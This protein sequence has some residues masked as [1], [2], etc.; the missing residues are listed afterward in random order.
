M[1]MDLKYDYTMQNLGHK[2]AQIKMSRVQTALSRKQIQN[3]L[4]EIEQKINEENH[5]D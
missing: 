3:K 4:L 5:S 2:L 1:A